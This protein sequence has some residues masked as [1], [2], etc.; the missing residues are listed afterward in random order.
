[1]KP[2][3]LVIDDEMYIR[4]NLKNIFLLEGYDVELAENG[5]EGINKFFESEP[6]V[7]LLDVMLPDMDSRE[8]LKKID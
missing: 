1:M 6:D 8:V 7:V 2:V 3:I 5:E 4:I